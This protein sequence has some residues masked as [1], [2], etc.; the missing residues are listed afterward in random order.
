[1]ATA[2]VTVVGGGVLGLSV[3]YACARRG[4]RVRLLERHRIGAGASGGLVGALA[5]HVPEPWNDKKAFQLDSLLAAGEFWA[6]AAALAGLDP[7]YARTGRLTPLADDAAVAQARDRAAAAARNWRGC[8]EWRVVAGGDDWRGRSPTGLWLEDT[9]SA[10]LAPRAAC[11]TLAAALRALGGRIEEGRDMPGPDAALPPGPVI[12]ATGTDGLA[13]LGADTGRVAGAGVKGQA[14]LLACAAPDAPQL[15][16]DG[17]HIVPHADNTVAVGSTSE[18]TWDLA[19][20]TDDRLETLIAAARAAS[21]LLAEAP[22]V[23]R[24][25]G[26]RPRA[27]SRAPL[28][29]PWPGRPG[30][31]V[32]NGGFKIGFGIAPGVGA[33]MARLVLDGVQAFP[34]AFLPGAA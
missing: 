34:D 6:G 30:H 26:L 29:G 12:W 22:V 27:V 10:R 32:A 13:A 15:F 18:R 8:A 21:P 19:H 25:A 11:R 16:V 33:A 23:A 7:G 2:D 4:A 31:F 28:L 24:W 20:A 1:M 9:L 14:A 3:A 17:L 5:P